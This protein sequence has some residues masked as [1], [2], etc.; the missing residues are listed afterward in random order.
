M[1]EMAQAELAAMEAET[2]A[3][4]TEVV[5]ELARIDR[6]L[7]LYRGTVLPQSQAAVGSA[8]SAYQV[9]SVDFMT[10]LDNQMAV[11]RY[12]LEVVTLTAERGIMLAELEMLTAV[13]WVSSSAAVPA[14]GI[15]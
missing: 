13:S 6:L 14:G 11:N 1:R 4:V 12:R 15:Q 9:G 5:A 8:L 2:R 3:R 7:D 10:L